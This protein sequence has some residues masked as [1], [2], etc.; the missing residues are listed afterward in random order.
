MNDHDV[1][2][3]RSLLFLPANR[4]DRL[5]KALDSGADRVCLDLEDAVAPGAKE[6]ARDGM[7]S[8]LAEGPLPRRV[9]LRINSPRTP[10]GIRDLHMLLELPPRPL[11]VMLPKVESP[12]EM[13]W[14]DQ[15]L[16]PT[17]PE[18]R[19]QLLVESPAGIEALPDIAASTPRLEAILLGAV[20]LA[21]ETG[22][23]MGW[24]ALLYARSRVVQ[25][26]AGVGIASWDAVR[27]DLEDEAALLE[28]SRRARTLG[29][30]GKAAIHPRQIPPIHQAFTPS[31]E[32]VERARR[33][34]AAWE[35]RGGGGV[36]LLDGRLLERPVMLQARRIL[37]ASGETND[38]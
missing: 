24:D 27:I 21:A 29:F 12:E 15:L 6:G 3:M 32:E 13:R 7:R 23:D 36:A 34:V 17:H 10:D 25:A 22:S 5:Q 33:V 18:L 31:P 28:E 35:A 30:T 16:S 38:G 37:A 14:M 19:L 9:I 26:T 4:L 20:D 11:A 1:G 8:L 2:R